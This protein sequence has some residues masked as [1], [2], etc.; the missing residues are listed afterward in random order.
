MKNVEKTSLQYYFLGF[1]IVITFLGLLVA[2]KESC[3]SEQ[4]HSKK[5]MSPTKAFKFM[6]L[7]WFIEKQGKKV[8]KATKV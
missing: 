1:S 6:N 4:L 2:L 5:V 7:G 8:Y 3:Y